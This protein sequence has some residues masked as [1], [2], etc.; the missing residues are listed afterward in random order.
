[1]RNSCWIGS[2]ISAGIVEGLNNQIRIVTRRSHSFRSCKAVE[3]VFFHMLGR[4]PEPESA[5]RFC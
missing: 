1:M 4:L 2:R 3:I 5:H